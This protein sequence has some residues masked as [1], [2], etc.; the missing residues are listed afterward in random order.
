[1]NEQTLNVYS[2]LDAFSIFIT[3]VI[4]QHTVHFTECTS[5]LLLRNDMLLVFVDLQNSLQAV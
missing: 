3:K 2:A 4:L 5:L 1:M